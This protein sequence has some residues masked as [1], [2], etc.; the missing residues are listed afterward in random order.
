MYPAAAS[1]HG[2]LYHLTGYEVIDRRY[3]W[4]NAISCLFVYLPKKFCHASACNFC[5][6]LLSLV[7]MWASLL[8]AY[9]SG[10]S[11]YLGKVLA[12]VSISGR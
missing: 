4:W 11:A 2:G 10:S 1:W 8:L 5:L 6:N 7:I 3:L 9:L 12:P